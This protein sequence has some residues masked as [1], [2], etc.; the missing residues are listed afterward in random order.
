MPDASAPDAGQGLT[1]AEINRGRA[2]ALVAD[3]AKFL[4]TDREI[5][6]A[7]IGFALLLVGV[8]YLQINPANPHD[9]ALARALAAALAE[10]LNPAE[11]KH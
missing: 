5:D 2:T 11:R 3:F 7:A 10:I 9:L 8:R 1:V 6:G 4:A